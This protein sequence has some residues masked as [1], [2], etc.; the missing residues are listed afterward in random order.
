MDALFKGLLTKKNMEYVLLDGDFQILETS[1]EAVRF[2]D[3]A[4]DFAL[5]SDVRFSF[6]ELFGAEEEFAAILEAKQADW[7][8]PGVGRATGHTSDLF[9]F[10][11]YVT[12]NEV[13]SDA[14]KRLV[15]ILE[16]VTERMRMEQELVMSAN[17]A[18][19]LADQL[20]EINQQLEV[21]KEAAESA[22]HLKSA[23]LANMSHEIRTPL[24][25]VIGMTEIVLDTDLASDQREYLDMVKTSAD[26][27]LVLL[28]DILDL[29]KIEAGKLEL[30][31]VNFSLRDTISSAI[32]PFALKTD[33]KGV[34]LAARVLPE[35]S[36]RTKLFQ[37]SD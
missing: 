36:N 31:S 25:G 23:F 21:A 32:N 22:N 12:A 34:E 4:E 17:R 6:P 19:L 27:L 35:V 11:I 33:Q 15:V 28:N 2:A 14:E 29:S 5:G 10:D 3:S 9:Y 26:S 37:Y 7:L 8:F 13:D 24:G 16:D 18:N 30:E 20:K 1:E